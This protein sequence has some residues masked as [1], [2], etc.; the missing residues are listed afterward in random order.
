[1]EVQKEAKRAEQC[2]KNLLDEQSAS[3]TEKSFGK[4]YLL[5]CLTKFNLLIG[6]VAR[7]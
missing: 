2:T 6:C 4:G 5:K 1:M 3:I 7:K